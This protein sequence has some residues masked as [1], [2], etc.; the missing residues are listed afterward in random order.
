[1]VEIDILIEGTARRVGKGWNAVPSTILLTEGRCR[2]IVDPGNHPKLLEVL[3][4]RSICPEDIGMVFITHSHLD[5]SLNARLFPDSPIIDVQ[6][7]HEG[8]MIFP[9]EG[10]LPGTD[11]EIIPTPGHSHDHASLV[12]GSKDGKTAI[13][14]DLFWWESSKE[15]RT[16]LSSLLFLEDPFAVDKELLLSSRR[17][18]LGS[19][20]FFIPGHG[21]PFTIDKDQ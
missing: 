3:G 17:T 6:F 13:C 12:I 14:G 7:C 11:I 18:I 2:I 8:T 19:A 9:H 4:A 1:M 16:D 21:K 15:Q 10:R 5:H 20:N